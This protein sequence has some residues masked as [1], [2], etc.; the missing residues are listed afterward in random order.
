MKLMQERDVEHGIED[1]LHARAIVQ[2]LQRNAVFRSSAFRTVRVTQDKVTRAL[3]WSTLAE[4]GK[5]FIVR[6]GWN[7]GLI[8]EAAS[9]PKGA[10]D[11]QI[12]A[13][14][15]AVGMLSRVKHIAMG[16]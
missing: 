7:K 12:D 10:N 15:I 1:A 4:E 16:F 14:S 9:F 3:S 6:A 5:V 11:D 13:I 2:D 8:E